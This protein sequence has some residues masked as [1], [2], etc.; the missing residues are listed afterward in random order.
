[1]TPS[2]PSLPVEGA[3]RFIPR[4]AMARPPSMSAG[5]SGDVR[6]GGGVW[7]GRLFRRRAVLLETVRPLEV[8]VVTETKRR[9]GRGERAEAIRYAYVAVLHD[10]ERAFGVEFPPHWTHAEILRDGLRPEM[11]PIPDFLGRLLELYEPVRYGAPDRELGDPTEL[12]VSIYS[13]RKMWGLYA[14]MLVHAPV[15]PAAAKAGAGP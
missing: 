13:H 11:A 4:P 1:M 10:L 6:P 12:L 7:M 2:G 14:E 9:Y 8:P 15:P 5:E 3:G